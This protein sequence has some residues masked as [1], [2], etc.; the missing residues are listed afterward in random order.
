M[1]KIRISKCCIVRAD[2]DPSTAYIMDRRNCVKETLD[3]DM[4]LDEFLDK[5]DK[6][7]LGPGADNYEVII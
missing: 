4:T 3:T 1:A 7:T 6:R 2:Q 5:M